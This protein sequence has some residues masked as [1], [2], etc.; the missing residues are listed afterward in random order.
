TTIAAVTVYA[1]LNSYG[2][3]NDPCAPTL[4]PSYFTP[5]FDLHPQCDIGNGCE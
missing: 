2:T 3:S 5:I 4:Y 1:V